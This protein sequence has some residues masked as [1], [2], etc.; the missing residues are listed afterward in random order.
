MVSKETIK[1]MKAASR[2]LHKDMPIGKTIPSKK[3]KALSRKKK[4][5]HR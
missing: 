1:D 5:K 2:K 3:E 4:H